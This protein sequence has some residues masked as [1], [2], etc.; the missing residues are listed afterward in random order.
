MDYRGTQ[1]W[2]VSEV[3]N[4]LVV[5]EIGLDRAKAEAQRVHL[6]ECG[7]GRRSAGGELSFRGGAK[8]GA[9]SAAVFRAEPVHW[10]HS[11]AR[12]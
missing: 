1:R 8:G 3:R 9:C 6:E 4:K 10:G 2:G 12:L 11:E 5:F 7:N